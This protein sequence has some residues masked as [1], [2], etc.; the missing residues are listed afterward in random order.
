MTLLEIAQNTKA[1]QNKDELLCLLEQVIKISPKRIL[2]IGTDQ[3]HSIKTWMDAFEPEIVVG[4]DL[5]ENAKVPPGA[6]M[7]RGNSNLFHVADLVKTAIPVVDFLFIDGNHME[8]AVERDFELYSPM[9]RKGGIVALHDV[10]IE[11]NN[12]VEVYRF[13]NKVK[14][15]YPYSEFHFTGG[16]GVG[17]LY[18]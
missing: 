15:S 14:K 1:S 2:E 4:V 3:G 13:W 18:L 17:L 12:S 11:D 9:V 5:H 6:V 7:I 10:F 8:H 16:T